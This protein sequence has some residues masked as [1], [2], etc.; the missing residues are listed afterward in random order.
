MVCHGD[1]IYILYLN[2]QMWLVGK[3]CP[4][5]TNSYTKKYKKYTVIRIIRSRIII[6]QHDEKYLHIKRI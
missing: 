4:T 3:L 2:D 5:T 1:P 6:L